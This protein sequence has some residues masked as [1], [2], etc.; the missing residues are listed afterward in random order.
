MNRRSYFINGEFTFF[1]SVHELKPTFY[2]I[3]YSKRESSNE[4]PFSLF[5]RTK[6]TL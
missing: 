1:D 4:P 2:E 3:P 5:E 6:E